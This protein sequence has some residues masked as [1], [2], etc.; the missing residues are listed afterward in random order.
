MPP[1]L[2]ST[3]Q[4]FKINDLPTNA[5]HPFSPSAEAVVHA[6]GQL[7]SSLDAYSAMPLTNPKLVSLLRQQASISQTL[8]LSNQNIQQTIDAL[9]KRSGTTYG[10]DIPI[11]PLA[12]V[13][14]CIER[15]E[16]WAKSA[17]M[18]SYK[19]DGREASMLLAGTVLV[20]EVEFSV[21]SDEPLKPKLD[22]ASVKTSYAIADS[23]SGVTS[24]TDGSISLDAFLA[25]SIQKFCTELE[26]P[27]D[28]RNP[29]EVAKLG[30]VVLD[31]LRYL[32]MLDKL[33]A[34]KEDGG[35]RW[36]V[37]IDQLCSILENF[38]KSEAEA[39]TSSL[40]AE[41][42]PLDIY[43]LRCHAL[44]LP[45]LVSPS[46]SFLTS[47]SPVPP[48]SSNLPKLDIPFDHLRSYV[49]TRRKGCNARNANAILPHRLAVIP[50]I[51]VDAQPNIAPNVPLV[52]SGADLEHV[53]PQ[54]A[55][56]T[57]DAQHVWVLD[58]THGG[59][60]PGVVVSQSRLR[61]MEL[62]I[63][64]LSGMDPLNPVMMSFG[65]GSWVALLLNPSNPISSERYAALYRSP[66]SIHPPLQLRLTL[67]EEPG[68]LL[69]KVP[70]HSM[71][72]VWGIL[73]VVR[74]Q[75]WLNEILLGCHWTTEGITMD[76]DDLPLDESDAT[77]DELQ[78]VLSGSITPRKIPVNIR[79]SIRGLESMTMPPVDRRTRIIMTCPERPPMSGVV[80]ITVAYNETRPR[81]TLEEISRRGGTLGLSGRIWANS[82]GMS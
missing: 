39:V 56:L 8:H 67:P 58:F 28:M 22:V 50:R 21:N 19:E 24:N 10:E 48:P 57:T 17:G 36:F 45:Y 68:F 23:D 3:L 5:A 35:V 14:W 81:D 31:H 32:V 41:S 9:R 63:H 30:G 29:R 61:E 40:G 25:G 60:F 54:I 16:S 18:E 38:S 76:A 33:A 78:A 4:R 47:S 73:E 77:E 53:F 43:L 79:S 80:E 6:I 15:L 82:R 66:T 51:A 70:V 13:G 27:E 42:A 65:T 75:C 64:P 37:D 72:E 20:V 46:I 74:E 44:P 71:K 69:G 59:E 26:K 55:E 52:P 62:V 2:L 12:I 1:T 7:S 34:R 11:D 49:S